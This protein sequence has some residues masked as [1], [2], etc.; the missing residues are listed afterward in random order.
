[1]D[2]K[3]PAWARGE[4]PVTPG[5]AVAALIPFCLEEVV[6][7]FCPLPS[8][9]AYMDFAL[10]PISDTTAGALPLHC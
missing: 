9:R 4:E 2:N 8:A 3:G 6:P 1:M 5:R 10:G 7:G